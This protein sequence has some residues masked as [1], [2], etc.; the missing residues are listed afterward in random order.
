M[1]NFKVINRKAEG[2]NTA[3]VL[4]YDAIGPSD[5][6]MVS[7]EDIKKQLDQYPDIQTINLHV[8]SPG[9]YVFEGLAI[10]NLLKD[11]PANVISHIDGYAAS[12]ASIVV[13]AGDRV[14]MAENAILM[15]HN[16]WGVAVGASNELRKEADILDQL[17][18]NLVG[19]YAART[20]M[21]PQKISDLMDA[22]TWMQ[23]DVALESKFVD[24]IIPNKAAAAM[25]DPQ[26]KTSFDLSMFHNV[27]KWAKTESHA[28]DGRKTPEI[29]WRRNLAQRRLDQ[30]ARLS[31]VST[32]DN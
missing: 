17:K 30:M 25:A 1:P 26:M 13:L 20:G 7:A 12:M 28:A 32:S 21:D 3:D 16:P 31:L 10:Y 23:S 9:G 27:P 15:I 24:E 2:K 19:I 8:N 11:H 29:P 22:E 5:W 6:G 14:K 18:V 4:I